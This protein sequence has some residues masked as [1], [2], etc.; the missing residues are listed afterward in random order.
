MRAFLPVAAIAT[1]SR[2]GYTTL[3][4]SRERP[5]V[6]VLGITPDRSTARRLALAWGVHA[7]HDETEILDVPDMVRR[8]GDLAWGEGFAARG[9]TILIAS[10]M[11]F[12]VAGTTNFLHIARA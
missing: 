5:S 9:Q 10:G 11:P 2:S 8:A 1:Y 12:G 7:V 4:A 3:R 6:P